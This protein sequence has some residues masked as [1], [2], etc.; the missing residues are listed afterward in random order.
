MKIE[1]IDR[2]DD[3]ISYYILYGDKFC[4]DYTYSNKEISWY[5]CNS[6]HWYPVRYKLYLEL[7]EKFNIYL[8]TKKLN[9]IL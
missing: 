5:A 6:N 9:R 7:E 4:R 1:F 8:R 3:G 2:M